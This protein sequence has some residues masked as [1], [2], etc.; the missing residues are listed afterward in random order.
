MKSARRKICGISL[1]EVL[2]AIFI[3]GLSAL[4]LA[5]TMPSATRS[6]VKADNMNKAAGAAQKMLEAVRGSGYANV[7]ATRLYALGLID[8][9]T[10]VATNT[11]SINSV[12]T[13][14]FDNLA[15]ILPNGTGQ[16][17]VEQIDLDLRRVTVV[18]NWTEKGATKTFRIGTLIANL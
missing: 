10:P 6:R 13:A 2:L 12:D 18:I 3:L 4:I 1:V 9:T 7:S 14:S 17:T 8:S 5:S 16:I 11:Y 15:K